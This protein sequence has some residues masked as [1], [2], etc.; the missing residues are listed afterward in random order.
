MN[1]EQIEKLKLLHADLDAAVAEFV[2]FMVEQ[3]IKI[4]CSVDR[5]LLPA[6]WFAC[7]NGEWGVFF[8]NGSRPLQ[9]ASP[10]DKAV[11]LKNAELLYLELQ[12]RIVVF[13]P[14]IEEAIRSWKTF[15]A[16]VKQL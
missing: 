7:L 3:P 15:R 11:A 16:A 8:G 9:K 1:A 13:R 4:E 6:L 14:G 12:K 2:K 5:G 10:A